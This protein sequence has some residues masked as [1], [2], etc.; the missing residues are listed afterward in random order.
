M[1]YQFLLSLAALSIETVK[2]TANMKN[3]KIP[4][5]V[6]CK[7]VSPYSCVEPFWDPVDVVR[8]IFLGHQP[9]DCMI[10]MLHTARAS[11]A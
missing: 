11:G 3:M 6:V 2:R 1:P 10:F 4:E 7:M 8:P 5:F 9:L